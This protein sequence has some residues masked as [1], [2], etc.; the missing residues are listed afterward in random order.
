MI[1]YRLHVSLCVRG[2]VLSQAVGS[3]DLGIDT[4]ALRDPTGMPALPGH[5]IRGNLYHSWDY[6][7]KLLRAVGNDP[8]VW[9]PELWLGR[10]SDDGTVKPERAKLRFDAHWRATNTTASDGVRH[11]IALDPERG[12][13]AAMALQVIETPFAAG[14]RPIFTGAIGA[15]LE[16][17]DAAAALAERIRKGLEYAGSVGALKGTG[18]GRIEG[19]GVEI[20]ALAPVVT[21]TVVL[22][23]ES[24]VGIMLRLDRPFCVGR[25]QL[26]GN[27]FES[28]ELIPGGVIRGAMARRLFDGD[29]S[30]RCA[31]RRFST[32][33]QHFS[34]LAVS[35][36]L[37]VTDDGK[38]KRPVAP[39]FSLV[40]APA[41]IGSKDD[42]LFDVARMFE[43]AG[44]IHGR[45]PAFQVDWKDDSP[46]RVRCGVT[47]D[48]RRLVQVRTAIEP[49]RGVARKSALFATETVVPDGHVWLA[50]VDLG[51]IP[52]DSRSSV[53]AELAL[54]LSEPLVQIGKTKAEADVAIYTEPFELALKEGVGGVLLRD[55]C[56]CICLQSDALLLPEPWTATNAS[57]LERCYGKA[58]LQLSGG[59]LA[60]QEKGYFARQDLVGG[61][62]LHGRFNSDQRPYNPELITRAGSVFVLRPTEKGAADLAAAEAILADWRR[63]GLDQVDAANDDDATRH[64]RRDWR[65]NPYIRENGYGAVAVN[66]ELHWALAPTE[67]AW[68]AV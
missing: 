11:R 13:V 10:K 67:G 66:L 3:R 14:T 30:E 47:A 27:L 28:Q 50:N 5:L 7:A 55:G 1:T 22:R 34:R 21:P 26:R 48:L 17:N 38:L 52:Q 62:Y 60:L 53:A 43:P 51:A 2:P 46:A 9:E 4:A 15:E 65:H 31:D 61:R 68:N 6:F 20:E 49:G 41:Y 59:C 63:R 12:A 24:R 42:K 29:R 18:F 40:T 32:L 45:A 37:P 36:A 23:E 25:T 8:S 19:V 58:W 16:D 56:A 39:P 54:L 44:L 64:R 33:C 57:A 35:H